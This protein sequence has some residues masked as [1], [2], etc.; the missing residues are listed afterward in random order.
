ERPARQAADQASFPSYPQGDSH[1]NQPGERAE[2]F[3]GAAS[4]PGSNREPEA[5]KAATGLVAGNLNG[6]T[7]PA[8]PSVSEAAGQKTEEK[9]R[10]QVE[11]DKLSEANQIAQNR[12]QQ[13]Q[14]NE[15][16]NSQERAKGAVAG[17]A[18]AVEEKQ[19]AKD[20]SPAAP[21][22]VSAL[23]YVKEAPTKGGERAAVSEQISPRDAQTL[24]DDNNKGVRVLRSGGVSPDSGRAKEGRNTIRPKDSEPPRPEA[25]HDENERRIAKKGPAG[26]FAVRNRTDADSVRKP[27]AQQLAKSQKLERR[28][29]N[30]RVRLLAGT[31]TD[32][33]FKADK[34]IPAVTLVRDTDVYKS[35]LE[36]QPGLRALLAGFGADERVIVVYKKIIYTVLP[37]KD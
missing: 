9:S 11:A 17:A 15:Q 25:T 3:D 27:A 2:S 7:A 29:E 35:A 19:H 23:Q 14:Q 5:G 22:P 28:V 10:Q 20:Q 36:K 32:R 33:D 34:E 24:P 12:S 13:N 21:N 16:Q 4:P 26:E 31:W 30:K 18:V 6:Q 37:P 8:A 1:L